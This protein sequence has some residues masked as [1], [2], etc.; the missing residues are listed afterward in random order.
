MKMFQ[1]WNDT[2]RLLS[3]DWALEPG[4]KPIAFDT[5]Y[6][7]ELE[8]MVQDASRHSA[9]RSLTFM[10]LTLILIF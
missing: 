1:P 3:G 5:R 10:L 2:V 9:G 8:R 7:H 4:R 6:K